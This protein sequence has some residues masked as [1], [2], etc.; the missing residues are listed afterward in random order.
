MVYF[1]HTDGLEEAGRKAVVQA[2]SFFPTDRP[3]IPWVDPK[4]I[5][6]NTSTFTRGRSGRGE[7]AV[8]FEAETE[9]PAHPLISSVGEKP[10]SSPSFYAGC[11]LLRS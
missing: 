2:P 3:T 7:Q 11:C 4:P 9:K 1:S 10:F 8:P 5:H 6:Q